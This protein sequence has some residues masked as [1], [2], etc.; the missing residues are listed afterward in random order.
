MDKG[1]H[2]FKC[3]FQ[4]HTPRDINWNGGDAISD[5]ERKAYAEELVL[6]CRDKG[7]NAVAITDHHDL[8]FFKYVKEA[9]KNERNNTGKYY[10]KRNQLVVFPGM[11]LT[12]ANPAS[13]QAILILDADIPEDFFVRIMNKLSLTPSSATDKSTAEIIPISVD[14]V[15]G[16]SDMYLKL[17]TVD[18]LKGRYIV[19]PNLSDGHG[20]ILRRGFYEHYKKMPCVGGYV[21]GICPT[22]NGFLSKINGK[23]RNYGFKSV[24]VFQTSDNRRRDHADLGS[25]V[26][27]VKW[28]VP[29]AEAIRQACLARESRISQDSPLLPAIFITSIDVSSSKFMGQFDCEFNRQYNAIIGGRGTGKSTILEYLRWGLCDQIYSIEETYEEEKYLLRS[30]SLIE[31]TL[32]DSTVQ[33]SFIKNGI[34]HVV[35]RKTK[36]NEIF[37]KIGGGEF[38]IATEENIRGLLPVQ[39]YS[40]KQLS[41]VG[42][43][44]EELKRLVYSPV[45][46]ELNDFA[47]KFDELK[48][49][50]RRCYELKLRKKQTEVEI[51]KSELELKSLEEQV[52][53][54]REGLKGISDEDRAV[55][56]AHEQYEIVEQLVD[57]WKGELTSAKQIVE[58]IK[59]DILGSPSKILE[60]AKLSDEEQAIVVDIHTELKNIFEGI[61]LALSAIEEQ[62]DPKG[63]TLTKLNTLLDKATAI[64]DRHKKNYEAAKQKST[65]QETTLT[66][67]QKI[68]IRVKE[69]RKFLNEKKQTISKTGDPDT[70]FNELKSVWISRHK[71]RADLLADQCA[72]L[73]I[74]S[75]DNLRSILGRGKGTSELENV[76]KKMIERSGARKDNIEELCKRISGAVD[77]IQE[78][79]SILLEFEILANLSPSTNPNTP[80]PAM[81]ILASIFA[82]N[83]L[84]KMA[85]RVTPENLVDLFLIQLDDVPIFEY[86]TGDNEYIPFNDASAGQQATALMHVLLNQDG[87]PL[88][89]DQPEDDLDNQMVSEIAALIWKAKKKRQLIF[90]SHN[91]NIVVNG[92]AELVACCDY[93]ITTDQSK[94]AIKK[95]GAIDIDDVRNEITKVMEGGEEAFKLRKEK[96]GF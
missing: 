22:D 8:L 19:L 92:D 1:A 30:R 62:L 48:A 20:G 47:V 41:T 78:W 57:N 54:L 2:F 13:C 68:E 88:I 12:F 63:A 37:L 58:N 40:Q 66:Q 55:I 45:R 15:N 4:I 77:P 96:Y 14:T 43:R 32:T 91:A 60:D 80:L 72:K 46:Q 29:T 70:Q 28:A 75:D 71:E 76:L 38:E 44:V 6:A 89:I 73:S 64:F 5:E 83:T 59:R 61:N 9:A 93:K 84:K 67:I 23:D 35:R 74:L 85:E 90:A 16:L 81:P 18:G 50:I 42:I 82:E 3:D 31:K 26:S 56:S 17:D 95:L 52:G 39:A 79:G 87:P 11:E 24:A 49:D 25:S 53:C 7:I 27:W 10:D 34:P 86:K 69:I 36:A 65:S 33:V 21:D 51:E 94:G